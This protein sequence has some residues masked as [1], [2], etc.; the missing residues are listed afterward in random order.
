[1]AGSGVGDY[2]QDDDGHPEQ[3]ERVNYQGT[4]NPA[5][6]GGAQLLIHCAHL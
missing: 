4:I 3:G 5:H 6:A 2:G 1:M